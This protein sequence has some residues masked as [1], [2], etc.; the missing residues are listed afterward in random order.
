MA[1]LNNICSI[2]PVVFSFIYT[3]KQKLHV[4]SA[5]CIGHINSKAV[6]SLVMEGTIVMN[7]FSANKN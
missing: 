6:A 5:S 7:L 3:V 4:G 1:L 2:F